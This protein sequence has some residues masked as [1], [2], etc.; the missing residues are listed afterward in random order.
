MS[1]RT[2]KAAPSPP[3]MGFWRRPDTVEEAP[4]CITPELPG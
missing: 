4:K 1:F 2:S 3:R